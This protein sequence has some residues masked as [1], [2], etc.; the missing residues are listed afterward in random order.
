MKTVLGFRYLIFKLLLP[1]ICMRHTAGVVKR[2]DSAGFRETGRGEVVN[3][4]PQELVLPKMCRRGT[5]VRA[6]LLLGAQMWEHC[7]HLRR[8]GADDTVL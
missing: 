8:I 2:R 3:W 4:P 7:C 6:L 1:R 5:H